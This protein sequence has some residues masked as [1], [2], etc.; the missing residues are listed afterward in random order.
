MKEKKFV[1]LNQ[2]I[3]KTYYAH[4]RI[5]EHAGFMTP[6]AGYWYNAQQALNSFIIKWKMAWFYEG[7]KGS[8]TNQKLK[9]PCTWCHKAQ[10]VELH[11]LHP[12]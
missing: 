7:S 3:N 11:L 2:N 4:N 12:D 9:Q 6:S 10:N 5:L 1:N 8:T